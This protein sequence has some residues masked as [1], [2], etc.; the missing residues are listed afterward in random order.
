MS[1]M[2]FVSITPLGDGESVSQYVSRAVKVIKESGLDWQ[3]TP[4][5]TVLEGDKLEDVLSV[6]NKAAE[7]LEE[8]NRISISIKID[9]RRNREGGLEKKVKS[10]MEKL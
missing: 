2:A 1:A 4:M 6:I 5:G 9:Y 3:L 7:I 10:V 8:C